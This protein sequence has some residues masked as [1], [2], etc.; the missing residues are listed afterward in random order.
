MRENAARQA[1]SHS[2]SYE[3]GH[4]MSLRRWRVDRSMSAS[5]LRKACYTFGR[6]KI[7]LGAP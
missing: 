3:S 2:V 5:K 6:N 7:A 1:L 4:A